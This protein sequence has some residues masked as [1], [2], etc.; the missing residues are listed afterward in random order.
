[1]TLRTAALAIMLCQPP[2]GAD[3]VDHRG[4]D[5]LQGRVVR[6]DDGGV[7]LVTATGVRHAIAWDR[8]RG[9]E[10]APRDP[11]LDKYKADAMNLWRARTRVE[12]LDFALAEPLFERLF[13]KYRGRKH[14]TAL[15]VAEG[16]LRCRLARQ[17][18][19][20]AI[21]PALEVARLRRADITTASYSAQPAILDETTLLCPDLPPAW[22]DASALVSL[23]R[24]LE[25]Y[26]AQGDSV[27]AEQA[28]LY[29][30]AARFALGMKS[31]VSGKAPSPDHPGAA[32]LRRLV[33]LVSADGAGREA[34]R[35]SL[36][37][38]V[39]S[40]PSWS[41]AWGRYF[42]GLSLLSESDPDR[43]E[44]GLVN[45]AYL[46]A[47]YVADQPYLAALA[48]D[49]L[50]RTCDANGQSAAAE[51]LRAELATRF[52]NHPSVARGTIELK[53]PASSK[54]SS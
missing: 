37:R 14:E 4:G 8:V 24:D 23:E 38:D 1:M 33:N 19:E 29:R 44:N 9:V 10:M 21:I 27:I 34:A 5:P 22:L 50:I 49:Q 42:V 20:W 11:D 46:P 36:R 17:A 35:Q 13:E 12:R 39:G 40:M 16:L 2:V 31:S 48:L 15:V 54:E 25:T 30:Q 28:S 53:R 32:L 18:N 47:N 3:V 52:P 7:E 6:I 43:R 41:A 45:L 26:D 51:S